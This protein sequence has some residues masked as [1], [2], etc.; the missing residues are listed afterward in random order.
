MVVIKSC[1]LEFHVVVCLC[2]CVV[3]V[4]VGDRLL[5]LNGDNVNQLVPKEC[6]TNCRG[7]EIDMLILGGGGRGGGW[8]EEGNGER[9]EVEICRWEEMEDLYR[10]V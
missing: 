8:R 6:K 4:H 3:Q 5:E 7:R 10:L 1:L 9:E 2:L